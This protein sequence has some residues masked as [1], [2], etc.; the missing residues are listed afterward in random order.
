MRKSKYTKELLTKYASECISIAGVI[1]KLELRQSGGNHSHISRK[2]KYYEIDISHFLGKTSNC[3]KNHKGS[4]KNHWTKILIKKDSGARKPSFIL[5]RALIESG[6]EYKCSSCGNDG[7]WNGK[8]LRLQ[9]D[10]KNG[11]WLNNQLENL[12]FLCPN[13]HSQTEG[14]CGNKGDSDLISAARASR[15]RLRRKRK[16][17]LDHKFTPNYVRKQCINCKKEIS[18]KAKRCKS[19]SMK[20]HETKIN[21]PSTKE[22][23]EMTKKKSFLQVGKILGVSDNA[24]RKRLKKHAQVLERET[25]EA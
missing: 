7:K 3:G 15:N 4:K 16:L 19:C 6:R 12:S 11:D 5:R 14:W 24:I 10:H 18:Q 8:E 17:P 20:Q 1:R 21:W 25:T 22:L 2:L 13:C 9:I 23:I